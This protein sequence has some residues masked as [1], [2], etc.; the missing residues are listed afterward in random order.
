MVAIDQA[1]FPETADEFNIIIEKRAF[2]PSK[3][4]QWIYDDVAYTFTSVEYQ[5]DAVPIVMNVFDVAG[6]DINNLMANRLVADET[7]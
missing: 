5:T 1:S 2:P 7:T 4:Q 6:T 3:S